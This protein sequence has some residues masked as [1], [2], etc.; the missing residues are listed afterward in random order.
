MQQTFYGA[1]ATA[2]ASCHKMAG[3]DARRKTKQELELASYASMKS[4]ATQLCSDP[5]SFT[6]VA[7]VPRFKP[8]TV[9]FSA[10]IVHWRFNIQ[11][12]A[13]VQMRSCQTRIISL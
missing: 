3:N 13:M 8:G 12:A 4:L 6:L 1:K 10:C 7:H 11:F 2:T 5:A 9:S